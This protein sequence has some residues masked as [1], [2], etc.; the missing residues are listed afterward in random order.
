MSC[1]SELSTLDEKIR[2]KMDE[3]FSRAARYFETLLRDAKAQGVCHAPNPAIAAQEMLSY[4]AGVMYQAK[5]KNDV[6]IIRRDL[7]P[8]LM[9]FFDIEKKYKPRVNRSVKSVT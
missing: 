1:G 5:I 3:M 9:R 8:G 7:L 6:E 2:C 4:V